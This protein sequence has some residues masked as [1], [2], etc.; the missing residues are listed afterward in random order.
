MDTALRAWVERQPK[1]GVKRLHEETQ[2][3]LRTLHRYLKGERTPPLSEALAL[4]EAT[5]SA[6]RVEDMVR[7]SDHRPSGRKRRRVNRHRVA[8]SAQAAR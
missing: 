2:I 3:P 7:T 6:V 4:S 8:S 5:A 1:G